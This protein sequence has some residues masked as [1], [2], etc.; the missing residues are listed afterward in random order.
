MALE[1]EKESR[2]CAERIDRLMQEF[3]RSAYDSEVSDSGRNVQ[4][5]TEEIKSGNTEEILQQLTYIRDN[6]EKRE[7]KAEAFLLTAELLK[8]PHQQKEDRLL[9]GKGDMFGIYQLRDDVMER[10]DLAFASMDFLRKHDM[11]VNAENYELVYAAPL[12]ALDSMDTAQL[13]EQVFE[14]RI[15]ATILTGSDLRRYRT[16]QRRGSRS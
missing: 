5:L 13:L 1:M 8:L 11:E 16:L 12:S 10:H 15:R 2:G 6:A 3:D 7:Q 14:R 9:T 4:R